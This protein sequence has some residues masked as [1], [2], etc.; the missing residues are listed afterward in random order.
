[1]TVSITQT[2]Q[3]TNFAPRIVL[4]EVSGALLLLTV[5]AKLTSSALAE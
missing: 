1:M 4:M 2:G 3:I 5:S